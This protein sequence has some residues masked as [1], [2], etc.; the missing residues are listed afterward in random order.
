MENDFINA[1]TLRRSIYM[2]NDKIDDKQQEIINLIEKTL[3]AAPS[4]FNS[5][6]SRIVLL[7]GQ[8]HHKLWKIT[9]D[10][11]QKIVPEEKF[12]TTS[13]KL[14]TFDAAYATILFFEDMEVVEQLQKKF[15][16]YKDNF[17]LWA[18]QANAMLQFA[19]WCGLA[20]MRIGANLQHYNP[21]IDEDVKKLW[22][23]PSSWQLIAQMPLGGIVQPAGEKTL[24]PLEQKLKIFF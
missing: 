8:Q 23:I 14:K 15:P 12:A 10:C 3:S 2:L 1:L 24:L 5:Q 6:S 18:Q 13:A 7:F 19:I 4:S 22:Q 9:H 20:D 16:L 11:L 21:L 17:P